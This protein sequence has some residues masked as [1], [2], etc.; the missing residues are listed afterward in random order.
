MRRLLALA[1]ALVSLIAAGFL[2]TRDR[3]VA[4]AAPPMPALAPAETMD[5]PP[6]IKAPK[7]PI[8][9]ADREARRFNRY[10]KDKDERIDR[11]EYLANR[12]KAYAK[13]DLN[14]DGRLDFDEYSAATMR[15]L[16]K[17]DQNR[18]GALSR[19]EFAT[20]AVKRKPKP[21]CRC[22]TPDD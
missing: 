5:A 20:T 2:W 19:D 14:K 11:A 17:A 9:D 6:P 3:P 7:A 12:K 10:D 4:V 16:N 13:L 22:E 8:T 15:K 18:D 21:E 1:L